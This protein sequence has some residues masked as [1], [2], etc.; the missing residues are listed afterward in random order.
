MEF[1]Y[2]FMETLKVDYDCQVR[3]I[4]ET[5]PLRKHGDVIL[6]SMNQTKEKWDPLVLIRADFQAI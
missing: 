4:G 2:V 5:S 1:I 6:N 3:V